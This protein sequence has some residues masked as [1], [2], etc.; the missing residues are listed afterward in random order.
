MCPCLALGLDAVTVQAYPAC[1]LCGKPIRPA[2][3]L[4]FM[5]IARIV[6]LTQRVVE[7]APGQTA[8]PCHTACAAEEDPTVPSPW[9]DEE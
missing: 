8:L 2:E 6:M 4:I 5:N 7:A 9:D 1:G 3:D